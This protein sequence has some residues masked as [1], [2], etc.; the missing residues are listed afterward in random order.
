MSD[1]VY[2]HLAFVRHDGCASVFLFNV[3]ALYTLKDGQRV[4]VST[5]KGLQEGTL[6]GNSFMVGDNGYASIIK[7][8]GAYKPLKSVTGIITEKIIRK[9]VVEPLCV[10]GERDNL[11]F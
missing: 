1:I 6:I 11:P 7:A 4:Q 9:K 2:H 10:T 8:V 5:K 3:D